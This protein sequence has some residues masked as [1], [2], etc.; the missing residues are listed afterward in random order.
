MLVQLEADANL[1][2]ELAKIFIS[3]FFDGRYRYI[4]RVI[5]AIIRIKLIYQVSQVFFSFELSYYNLQGFF[6]VLIFNIIASIFFH[7]RLR[8][9]F[10]RYC[11]VF[12]FSCQFKLNTNPCDNAQAKRCILRCALAIRLFFGL[13]LAF[14]RSS[15]VCR[16]CVDRIQVRNQLRIFFLCLFIH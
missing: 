13:Y 1:E 15:S 3:M 4:N 2:I 16:G 11:V 7:S 9:S 6:V 5:F 14:K 8:E 10:I 12:T